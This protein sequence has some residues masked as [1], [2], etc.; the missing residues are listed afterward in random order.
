MVTSYLLS[1][2]VVSEFMILFCMPSER[3]YIQA[4][5]GSMMG[6]VLITPLVFPFIL[7]GFS[8]IFAI[9]YFPITVML[10]IIALFIKR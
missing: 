10:F 8:S 5:V 3:N 7:R 2:L 9:I 1:Y 4:Q 6:V